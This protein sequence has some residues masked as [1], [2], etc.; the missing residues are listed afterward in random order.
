MR[1]TG[2]IPPPKVRSV[3]PLPPLPKAWTARAKNAV[4]QAL[5]LAAAAAQTFRGWRLN[6]HIARARLWAK[7]ERALAEI[8][9]LREQVRILLSRLEH[10]PAHRRPHYPP[11]ERLAILELKTVRN[12]SL[13]QTARE[14]VL[15]PLTV[16]LWLKRLDEG[17]PAALLQ[18]P[19]PVNKYPL[20]V[21]YIV[22]WLKVAKALP[23]RP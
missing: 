4:I 10:I 19:V 9:L 17:G 14:F 2:R 13:A 23:P 6:S 12:W 7:L 11:E 16:A 18:T 3:L 21:Q 5:A 1:K 15:A 20:L 22:Q 8:A